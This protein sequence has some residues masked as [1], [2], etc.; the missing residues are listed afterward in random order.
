MTLALGASSHREVARTRR[1]TIVLALNLSLVTALVI[2]GLA[3]HSLA[4]LAAGVDYLAGRRRHRRVAVRHP[5]G[6]PPAQ[7]RP[8]EGLSQRHQLARKAVSAIRSS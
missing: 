1:L 5:A 4:V 8:P 6:Q 3:A 7:P 2:V